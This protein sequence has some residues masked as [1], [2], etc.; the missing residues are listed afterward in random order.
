MTEPRLVKYA[1]PSGNSTPL[2]EVAG[3]GENPRPA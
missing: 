2:D 1:G 3:L